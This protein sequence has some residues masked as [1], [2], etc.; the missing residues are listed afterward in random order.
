MGLSLSH[1]RLLFLS[2][3][4]IDKSGAKIGRIIVMR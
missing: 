1:V 4:V 3:A 2:Y